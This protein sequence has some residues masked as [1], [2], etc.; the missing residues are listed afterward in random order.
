M[1]IKYLLNNGTFGLWVLS[2]RDSVNEL[3]DNGTMVM[4]TL[5]SIS[6]L[7]GIVWLLTRIYNGIAD[8]LINRKKTALENE[9]LAQEIHEFN[10]EDILKRYEDDK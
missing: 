2:A 4:D 5:Q 1:N 7:V 9:R 8:G 10:D 6:F 3:I